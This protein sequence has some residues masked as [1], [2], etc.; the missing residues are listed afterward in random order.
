MKPHVVFF[1]VFDSARSRATD[2]T[3]QI[4][5]K[6][7]ICFLSPVLV[8]NLFGDKCLP[9]NPDFVAA[10]KSLLSGRKAQ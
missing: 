8:S 3:T 7:K 4:L 2:T 9:S 1:K 5:S 6:Y 10:F